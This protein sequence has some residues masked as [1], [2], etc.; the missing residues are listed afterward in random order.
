MN[1]NCTRFDRDQS[2]FRAGTRTTTQNVSNA[3]PAIGSTPEV[4][5]CFLR[6]RGAEP[7]MIA[8]ARRSRL[9]S[10]DPIGCEAR[11]F[12]SRFGNEDRFHFAHARSESPSG[13]DAYRNQ[14]DHLLLIRGSAVTKAHSHAA[15]PD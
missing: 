14:G 2:R 6:G 10:T 15:E 13:P 11:R 4:F 12:E 3:A 5:L 7:A 1:C 9:L 8:D